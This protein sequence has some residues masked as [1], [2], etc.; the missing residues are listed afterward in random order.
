M[1]II[2]LTSM[3]QANKA[4]SHLNKMRIQSR[5]ERIKLYNRGCGYGLRVYENPDKICEILFRINIDCMEI[6]YK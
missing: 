2:V 1:Y 5:I 6:I 4:Q 3:T